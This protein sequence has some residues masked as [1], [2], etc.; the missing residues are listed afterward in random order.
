MD[1]KTIRSLSVS[2]RRLRTFR[3]E[4]EWSAALLDACAPFCSRSALLV[5]N[6]GK[7]EWKA[8][9]GFELLTPQ[10]PVFAIAEAAAFGAAIES[11]EITVALCTRS[12]VS[13]AMTHALGEDGARRAML[14]PVSTPDRVAA[15]IYAEDADAAGLE[16]V[17][18][19][20][21]LALDSH[22]LRSRAS[23]GKGILQHIA[24]AL[25]AGVTSEEEEAHLRAQRFARKQAAEIRLYE[26]E[27][28][29]AGRIQLNLYE[30]A[31]RQRIDAAREA[32]LAQFPGVNIDYLH[33]ELVRV[34]ADGNEDAMGVDYPGP[35]R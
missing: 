14:A 12:E 34:L 16:V 30:G 28:V 1:S 26:S 33:R 3:S 35:A 31:V 22:S 5:V 9:K 32:F 4:K 25:P 23:V 7:L 19:A 6:G 20:A 27:R 10:G 18:I 29:E 24:P 17:A 2:F 11:R 21:G 13:P 8:S 15:V